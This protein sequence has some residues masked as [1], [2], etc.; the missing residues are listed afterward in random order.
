MQ[1]GGCIF[2]PSF[3]PSQP[4]LLGYPLPTFCKYIFRIWTADV[5]CGVEGK[6]TEASEYLLILKKLIRIPAAFE[7]RALSISSGT[8]EGEGRQAET[9]HPSKMRNSTRD[10]TSALDEAGAVSAA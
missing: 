3:N 5:A 7:P 2:M 8:H 9:N 10:S 6:G 1:A 4:R